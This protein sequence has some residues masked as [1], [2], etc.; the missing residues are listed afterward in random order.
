MKAPRYNMTSTEMIG[1]ELSQGA[2]R[3]RRNAKWSQYGADVLPAFVA[4][5]DFS[6]AAPIQAAMSYAEI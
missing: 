4:D 2:L 5:M 3:A 1:F 6:V